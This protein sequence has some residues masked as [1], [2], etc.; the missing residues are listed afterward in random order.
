M[1]RMLNKQNGNTKCLLCLA[2]NNRKIRSYTFAMWQEQQ[3]KNFGID[4]PRQNSNGLL[5]F[6]MA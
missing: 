5:W 2:Y 6:K 4:I 1:L 3:F